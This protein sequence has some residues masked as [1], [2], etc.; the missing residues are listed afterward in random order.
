MGS[1]QATRS[2]KRRARDFKDMEMSSSSSSSMAM[3]N[4]HIF[5]GTSTILWEALKIPFKNMTLFIPIL[6]FSLISSFLP[7]I[8][9][10]N[11][12]SL[13]LALVRP[14][15]SQ[16]TDLTAL[17]AFVEELSSLKL[18]FLIIFFIIT[19]LLTVATIHSTSM[20]YTGKDPSP[21]D[22]IF[23]TKH[24]WKWS[25]V[26]Q[27]CITILHVGFIQSTDPILLGLAIIS[28]DSEIL[29]ALLILVAILAVLYYLY[30]A[31]VSLLCLVV[32]A[33]EDECFCMAAVG[34][35]LELISRSRKQGILI[36][37]LVVVLSSIS[38]FIFR[39]VSSSHPKGNQ[40]LIGFVHICIDVVLNL[41]ILATSTVLYYECK[42]RE[43]KE[44]VI[45]LEAHLVHISLL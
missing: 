34:R 2:G 15:C 1:K 28:R 25:F 14:I 7:L 41:L 17:T 33:V 16:V 27:I 40:L 5:L 4:S 10:G 18:I 35:A 3:A 38:N 21:S 42:K 30:V 6:F 12:N 32:S 24:S 45:E 13:Y 23:M 43:R 37:F 26:T 29:V 20:A 39:V 19:S 9:S 36:T 31:I 8:F 11:N 44:N 22:I